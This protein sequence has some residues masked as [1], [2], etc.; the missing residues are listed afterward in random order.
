MSARIVVN[1][2]TPT[3]RL[4]FIQKCCTVNCDAVRPWTIYLTSSIRTLHRAEDSTDG[5]CKTVV[6]VAVSYNV[7]FNEITISEM[8]RPT[9]MAAV[10]Q[11]YVGPNDKHGLKASAFV[12]GECRTGYMCNRMIMQLTVK[13]VNC[14]LK[15]VFWYDGHSYSWTWLT[16]LSR[17]M[18]IV[19]VK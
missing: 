14:T 1:L 10:L 4:D 9:N 7:F 3:S 6:L 18:G 19:N 11:T 12:A 5:F 2:C 17:D 16:V 15:Q 13:G 8:L